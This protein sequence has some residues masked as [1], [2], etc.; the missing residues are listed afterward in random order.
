MALII[1]CTSGH[2]MTVSPDYQGK[3]VRCPQ[4][5]EIL[6]VPEQAGAPAMPA[7]PRAPED[8]ARSVQPLAAPAPGYGYEPQ[9]RDDRG[10][11]ERDRDRGGEEGRDRW[12][13]GDDY[14][15]RDYPGYGRR[16]RSIDAGASESSQLQTVSL[17]LSFTFYRYL[18]SVLMLVLGAA[19]FIM[20]LVLENLERQRIFGR[21]FDFR[22]S[23]T[24][25]TLRVLMIAATISILLLGLLAAVFTFVGS[26]LCCRAPSGAG[27][28]A[29]PLT[30][31]ILD[32]VGAILILVGAVIMLAAGP[33][34]VDRGGGAVMFIFS[35]VAGLLFLTAQALL[36]SFWY[37][38]GHY[39]GNGG[40]ARLALGSMI[41]WIVAQIL[42]PALLFL[43]ALLIFN[44]PGRTPTFPIALMII[45]GVW[46]VVDIILLCLF[47]AVLS[48]LKR[49]IRGQVS[50]GSY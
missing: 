25:E 20:G 31:V 24:E 43:F 21:G 41:T 4:C 30:S 12:N 34:W 22:V 16:S 46:F 37:R 7:P 2:R 13:G 35:L 1:Q 39:L 14:R 33:R 10:R 15:D 48:G 6:T 32:G 18:L 50:R 44:G 3:R 11:D 23:S 26:G 47:L 8:V 9:R 5:Q 38:L 36:S 45:I 49:S 27:G 17:G 42:F 19:L 29:L 40:S 28:A